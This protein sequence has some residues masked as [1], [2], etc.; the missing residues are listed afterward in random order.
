MNQREYSNI[1][2]NEILENVLE[3]IN[4]GVYDRS[5]I[6]K[7]TNKNLL[8]DNF[9]KIKNKRVRKALIENIFYFEETIEYINENGKNKDKI[10]NI[11][12]S[13]VAEENISTVLEN[14][15]NDIDRA[16]FLF[17]IQG[18]ERCKTFMLPYIDS[19]YLRTQIVKTLVDC[20][21][22][23]D[24]KDLLNKM[25][26]YND[27]KKQ[28]DELETEAEKTD[29]IINLQDDDLILELLDDIK[30]K[31][32]R[33]LIINS[34]ESEIDPSI[35]SQVELVQ[36]MIKE[37]FEDTL[38]DKFDDNKKEKMQIVFNKT[39]IIFK[40]LE[41]NVNATAYHLFDTI[42]ISER[43]KDNN[44]L[45]LGFLIHEYEHVFSNYN[46][47]NINYLNASGI[48]E[49]TAD[50][51]ADLV[52]NHYIEKHKKVELNGKKVRIDYPYVVS[53]G[54]DFEN[55]WQRTSLYG[56]Q[57]SGKDKEALAE[58][59]L[60]DKNKYLEMVLGRIGA[61]SK[62]RD[63]FGNPEIIF[64][65]EEIYNSPE[66]NFSN[67]DENSIYANRNFLLH[68][69]K[70]QNKLNEKG[71]YI[72]DQ[73][74]YLATYVGNAYFDN[75]K[76]YEISKE[77][78]QEFQDLIEAQ[79]NPCNEN[80]SNVV[81]IDGFYNLKHN[82]LSEEEMDEYSFEILNTS[83]AMWNKTIIYGMNNER[84]LITCLKKEIEKIETGQNLA[85]SLRKYMQIVPDY[86]NKIDVKKGAVNNFICEAIKDFQFSC[87]EQIRENIENGNQEEVLSALTKED[88][89]EI[90]LDKEII[91]VFKEYNIKINSK[92]GL[93]DVMNSDIRISELKGILDILKNKEK[94]QEKNVDELEI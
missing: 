92:N 5:I 39:D 62:N 29:F 35:N 25:N 2:E 22:I 90:Y 73:N 20:S 41:N 23:F 1:E 33:D 65:T 68:V 11:C 85:E 84:V 51:F 49:G 21:Y 61:N 89:K 27:V 71:V 60:G 7:I 75:R 14:I 58:Y 82:E 45:L 54:Y 70:L 3:A 12:S 26:Y 28:Y 46:F 64:F 88:T 77:E 40:E 63:G 17:Y 8:F 81:D 44:N 19:S 52:I 57:K 67:I 55:A 38:G 79:T 30:E 43:H 86:L 59:I 48:E 37:Y 18:K 32:K 6:E 69:F 94:L 72:L 76:L 4:R 47:K 78:M 80:S 34:L 53:S 16:K 36:K 93:E 66:L 74:N 87:L 50:F 83:I 24:K 91:E 31:E 42:A 56:L 15:S 10:I 13:L 9:D